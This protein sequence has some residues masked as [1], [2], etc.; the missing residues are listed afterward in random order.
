MAKQY[1]TMILTGFEKPWS[2]S[3][4]FT[5]FDKMYKTFKNLPRTHHSSGSIL[6]QSCL[7]PK[8]IKIIKNTPRLRGELAVLRHC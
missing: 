6:I 3:I 1:H 4:G 5:Q 8:D 7:Y 2:Q